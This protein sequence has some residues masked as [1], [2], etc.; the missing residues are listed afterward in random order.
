MDRS[1]DPDFAT[2]SEL[3][4]LWG[5]LDKVMK[6]YGSHTKYTIYNDE[7]GYI[8]HPPNKGQ[9]AS[10]TTA[11]YYINWAEY[12]SWKTSRIASTMQYLLYDPPPSKLL[13]MGGFDSGLL[14]TN[15]RPKPSY[16]AYRLPVFLPVTTTSPGRNIEV[17]GCARPA[18]GI[19]QDTHT[20]QS[21]QIQF[22]QGLHGA[23]RTVKTLQVT[24][25]TGY[26]DT[27]MAFPGTG[28]LRLAYTY[29]KQDSMLQSN[30]LGATVY[31]RYVRVTVR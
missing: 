9:F 21:V 27:H 16:D 2:F 13:P 1:S 19:S 24:G 4:R 10:P 26:F 17:W 8:T 14:T 28:E 12:L 30:A 31:S 7:Y 3:P 20:P 18:P 11:A 22:A 29:P 6:V 15:G 23:F 25:S 5:Q